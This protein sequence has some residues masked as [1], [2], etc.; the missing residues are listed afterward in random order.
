[1]VTRPISNVILAG[2]TRKAVLA[3]TKDPGLKVEERAI[4]LEEA[5]RAKEAFITSASNF[6]ISVIQIDGR[7]IGTGDVGPIARRMREHYIG[8]AKSSQG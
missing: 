8:F 3:L 2:C 1:V 6:V 4:A 7:K 5:Y